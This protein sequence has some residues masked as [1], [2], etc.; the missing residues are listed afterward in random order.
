MSM[1]NLEALR[2]EIAA[3]NA[4]AQAE[5]RH[6]QQS[7][8]TLE[9][10]C[11]SDDATLDDLQNVEAA[12]GSPSPG[13]QRQ[14]DCREQG[15]YYATVRNRERKQTLKSRSE[16]DKERASKEQRATEKLLA[17]IKGLSSRV[18]GIEKAKDELCSLNVRAEDLQLITPMQGKGGSSWSPSSQA[19]HANR[20][21]D[22]EQ[23][24]SAAFEDLEEKVWLET[25]LRTGDDQRLRQHLHAI[26][27]ALQAQR[28]SQLEDIRGLVDQHLVAARRRSKL[29]RSKTPMSAQ[30]LSSISHCF[31]IIVTLLCGSTAGAYTIQVGLD[32]ASRM[33]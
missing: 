3:L 9:K 1:G 22:E 33:S 19:S 23:R 2:E 7:L 10:V 27:E 20:R 17:R 14:Q 11:R 30:Y 15:L 29:Q 4:L 21:Q 16:S 5:R 32:A 31:G 28:E 18:K 25:Q 12:Y 6:R 13:E 24:L 8:G 26:L